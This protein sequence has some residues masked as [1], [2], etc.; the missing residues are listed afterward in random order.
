MEAVRAFCAATD[1]RVTPDDLLPVA[2]ARVFELLLAVSGTPALR[3]LS[4]GADYTLR[5]APPPRWVVFFCVG[6]LR[7]LPR[8]PQG[9]RAVCRA[10]PL[11]TV[12]PVR[13]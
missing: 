6:S 7:R 2:V 5:A 3:V 11:P 9:M 12:T 4:V 10:C 8:R 1:G 13:G